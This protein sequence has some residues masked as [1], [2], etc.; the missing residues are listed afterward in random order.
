MKSAVFPDFQLSSLFLE[1]T[2]SNGQKIFQ[3]IPK[4]VNDAL[5][6]NFAYEMMFHKD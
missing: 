4:L 5:C 2:L 1:I 6:Y 3:N